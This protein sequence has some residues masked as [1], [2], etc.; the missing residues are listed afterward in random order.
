MATHAIKFL[1]K[2]DHIVMIDKGK[3]LAAGSYK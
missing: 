1:D 2:A 3:I